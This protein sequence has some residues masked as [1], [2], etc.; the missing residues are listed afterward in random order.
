MVVHSRLSAEERD[1]LAK[2]FSLILGD[3]GDAD[4]SGATVADLLDS[5]RCVRYMDDLA[6]RLGGSS[7]LVAASMFVK[8][9]AFLAVVPCLYAMSMFNKG[10]QHRCADVR[11]ESSAAGG[12]S[13][14]S[15]VRLT[16]YAVTEPLPGR[17]DEWREHTLKALFGENVGR[18]LRALSRAAKAPMPI[19]WENAAVRV[20]SLYEKKIVKDAGPAQLDRIRDDYRYLI[21][22]AP[23]AVFGES[24][25]PLAAYYGHVG[26]DTAPAHA[27]SRTRTTCCFYY[28]VSAKQEYCTVCP[29]AGDG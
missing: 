1:R 8:R 10:L 20:Y 5:A 23:A 15:R 7:R 9:Y 21:G 16:E 4:C 27:A 22:E 26:C 11:L 6:A 29:K 14:I 12:E 13:W 28:T 3:P 2:Q 19:L 24:R 25:N 17:R 18:L